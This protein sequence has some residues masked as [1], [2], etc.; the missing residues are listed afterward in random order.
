MRLILGGE[1]TVSG[2]VDDVTNCFPRICMVEWV[3]GEIE[4]VEEEG[5]S[6]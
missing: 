6:G 4:L 1:A 3:R 2:K 5:A